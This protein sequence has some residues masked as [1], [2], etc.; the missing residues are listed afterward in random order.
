M[1]DKKIRKNIFTIRNTFPSNEEWGNCYNTGNL[2][3][4]RNLFYNIFDDE[5]VAHFIKTQTLLSKNF[6]KLRAVKK[7]IQENPEEYN[8]LINGVRIKAIEYKLLR[9]IENKGKSIN[10]FNLIKE[11]L[12]EFFKLTDNNKELFN[13]LALQVFEELYQENFLEG[14]KVGSK[15]NKNLYS[16][17]YTQ[18]HY[19]ALRNEIMPS[20]L[21]FKQKPFGAAYDFLEE[22]VPYHVTDH[23]WLCEYFFGKARRTSMCKEGTLAEQFISSNEF[24]AQIKK[25]QNQLINH[26]IVA[27]NY[28]SDGFCLI[29]KSLPIEQSA[30]LIKERALKALANNYKM[31]LSVVKE[32][33][34]D[35]KIEKFCT[36]YYN[37]T[38]NL[39]QP[40]KKEHGLDQDDFSPV[41][42]N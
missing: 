18:R 32:D 11:E 38:L 5:W 22:N 16:E 13:S 25:Y 15:T 30:A 41:W 37:G 33:E 39:N 26:A 8:T 9:L 23:N 7:F 27:C 14:K 1:L 3:I 10:H 42:P 35:D 29:D 24:Y 40:N 17:K 2:V 6:L 12:S 21:Q 36:S 19:N 20:K 4:Q 34:F 28:T 31:D